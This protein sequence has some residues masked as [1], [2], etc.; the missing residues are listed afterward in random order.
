MPEITVELIKTLRDKTNAGMMDCKAALKEADGDLEAAETVLR[1][2]GVADADKKAARATSEG[3]IAA[4]INDDAKTGVLVEVNCETDFV[5]KN[6]NFRAFV[7]TILDH[8]VSSE[9]SDD[10]DT[11]LENLKNHFTYSLYCNVCRSLFEKDKVRAP[12]I[13]PSNNITGNL[14]HIF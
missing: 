12:Q 3:T 13:T 6:E 4:R 7:E 2:M 11:R 5:A 8:V 1:K 10:L 14:R 9:K